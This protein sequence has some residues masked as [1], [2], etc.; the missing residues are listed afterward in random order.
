MTIRYEPLHTRGM[1]V[2][3]G[4]AIAGVVS[5]LT[6]KVREAVVGAVLVGVVAAS[7]AGAAFAQSGGADRFGHGLLWR[8]ERPGVHASYVYGT[9]HVSDPRV[10]QIPEAVASLLDRI[11]IV[12]TEVTFERRDLAR[13]A[14]HIYLPEGEQLSARFDRVEFRAIVE[15]LKEAGVTESAAERLTPFGAVAFLAA[16]PSA[17]RPSLD[18]QLFNLAKSNRL[19]TI[20]LETVDEQFATMRKVGDEQMIAELRAAARAPERFNATI[21]RLIT[22]YIEQSIGELAERIGAKAG[23]QTGEEIVERRNTRMLD[24]MRPLLQSGSAL[25]AVGAAHLGG[26]HGLLALLEAAGYTVTRAALR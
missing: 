23:G 9:L 8:V 4:T 24:R 22:S 17:S 10:A 21:E 25:I 26:E 13:I 6:R 11:A 1:A 12:A 7:F 3:S 14:S 5:A 18:L 15:M 20:G 19:K 2:R 16:R